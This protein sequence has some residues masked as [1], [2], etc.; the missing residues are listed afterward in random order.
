MPRVLRPERD[1]VVRVKARR[2]PP[3]GRA[4]THRGP[5]P[6]R[7]TLTL[8][9]ARNVPGLDARSGRSL[10]S[11]RMHLEPVRLAAKW[12]PPGEPPPRARVLYRKR[13]VEGIA[14]AFA[15]GKENPYRPRV[16]SPEGPMW[17]RVPSRAPTH[18]PKGWVTTA[19]LQLLLQ[20]ED[21]Y[22][23]VRAMREHLT[24]KVDAKRAQV[25]DPFLSKV[26]ARLLSSSHRRPRGGPVPSLKR[27]VGQR[28]QRVYPRDAALAHLRAIADVRR[29]RADVFPLKAW[30]EALFPRSREQRSRTRVMAAKVTAVVDPHRPDGVAGAVNALRMLVAR[31]HRGRA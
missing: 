24:K 16:Y 26:F 25:A 21:L 13:F 27:R 5:A 17:M 15:D 12:L 2:P 9:Q 18:V 1:R 20:K 10:S 4:R 22:F 14:H 3:R 28:I 31:R 6:P 11:V 7:G 29:S 19:E 23:T 8:E 30:I